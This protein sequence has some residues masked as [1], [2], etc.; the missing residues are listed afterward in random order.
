VACP[1]ILNGESEGG[2][3]FSGGLGRIR[4]PPKARGSGDLS[5]GDFCNFSIKRT[6]FYAYFAEITILKH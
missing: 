5:Q 3:K 2:W 1:G 6:H 4:Q